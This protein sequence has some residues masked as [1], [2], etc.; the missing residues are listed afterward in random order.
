LDIVVDQPGT[1]QIKQQFL[2]AGLDLYDNTPDMATAV[3]I[4]ESRW[5][6]MIAAGHEQVIASDEEEVGTI[7]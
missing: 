4:Y 6:P 7:I 5:L 3:E 2:L 1:L